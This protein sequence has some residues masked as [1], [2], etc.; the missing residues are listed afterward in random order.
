MLGYTPNGKAIG[1]PEALMFW[2]PECSRLK[3]GRHCTGIHLR[4]Q[5]EGSSANSHAT[6]GRSIAYKLLPLS[7]H[8]TL[9]QAEGYE[10][11]SSL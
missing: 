1:R 2:N 9:C 5:S 4:I 7:E 6:R 10:T 3:P 11:L 8:H